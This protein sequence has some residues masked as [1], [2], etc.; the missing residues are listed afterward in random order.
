[1]RV[2]QKIS[3]T[4][5]ISWFLKRIPRWPKKKPAKKAA[6]DSDTPK[7]LVE[8]M[9]SGWLETP[10]KAG[11]HPQAARFRARREALSKAFPGEYLLISAGSTQ[12]RAN[13]TGFRFRPSSDFAYLLGTGESGGL[14][15]LE[16]DGTSHRSSA[17][18]PRAQSRH[19]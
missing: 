1:M 12:T 19:R 18:R 7:A 15:V 10:L 14:L 16:P 13:D 6:H 8:F 17:I 4:R 9:S 11:I 5:K 3:K 2:P